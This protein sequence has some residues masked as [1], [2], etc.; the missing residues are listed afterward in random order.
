MG[1]PSHPLGND[2]A[3]ALSLHSQH[4]VPSHSNLLDDDAPELQSDDL[5]PLYD[6]IAGGEPSSSAP[7]LGPDLTLPA[8]P[9]STDFISQF[10]RSPVDGVDTYITEI[11][12]KDPK[13]LENKVHEWAAK[14]P[15]VSVQIRGTHQRQVDRDGKKSRETVTDFDVSVDLTPF[16][17]SDAANRLSW[18]EVNTVDNITKTKRGTVFKC[19]APGAK[20]GIELGLPEK[21]TLEEWCHR[22]C[23]SSSGLKRFTLERRMT[24]FKHDKVEDLLEALVR[25]TNYH[26]RLSITFPVKEQYVHV[27]NECKTNVWRMNKWIRWFCYITFLWIFTWPYLF[28]RTKVFEVVSSDWP[29][30]T[31]TEDLQTRYVTISEAQWYNMWGRAIHRAVLERRQC[32][33]DQQD[34]ATAE[35]PNPVWGNNNAGVDIIRAGIGAMNEINRTVGWGYDT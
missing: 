25:R 20:R 16:L 23:A 9:L 26:G 7:L 10:Y 19:R 33:L 15:R 29:F 5:P 3:D 30:S 22:Y 2:G 34:L 12:D 6:D 18:R 24:G 28:F 27:Y 32:T 11:L 21:P 31:T 1:K 13:L 17:F 4:G 14:P 35:V 8:D